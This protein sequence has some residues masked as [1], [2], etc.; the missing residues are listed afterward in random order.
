VSTLSPSRWEWFQWCPSSKKFHRELEQTMLES[1]GLPYRF[2]SVN[3]GPVV[4]SA[5]CKIWTLSVNETAEGLPLILLH[6]FGSGLALWALNLDE[7][8]M[9]RPVHAF[10]LLGK[11]ILIYFPRNPRVTL[12][13]IQTGFGASSRPKF[14]TSPEEVENEFIASIESW[15]LA[16]KIERFV[17]VGHS[18]GGFLACVYSIRY[19]HVVAGLCL[20]DPWGFRQCPE[21]PTELLHLST[22]LIL[23]LKLFVPFNLTPLWGLRFLGR[24]GEPTYVPW[25]HRR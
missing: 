22:P 12:D 20:A 11:F 8:A 25:T 18:F 16:M 23:L 2:R 15:R 6:G 19:P 9:S 13:L 7:L 1:L 24:I 21:N 4:G 10:D 14:S 3:I 5:D 17:L